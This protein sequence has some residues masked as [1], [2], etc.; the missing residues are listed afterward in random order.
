MKLWQEQTWL[1]KTHR[2]HHKLQHT[3]NLLS[4]LVKM[5]RIFTKGSL[6]SFWKGGGAGERFFS[7]K[8]SSKINGKNDFWMFWLSIK[9]FEV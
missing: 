4:P 7:K 3:L 2:F 6:E 8:F 5:L 9:K 1:T